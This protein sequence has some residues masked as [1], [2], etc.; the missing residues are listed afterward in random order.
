VRRR[1]DFFQNR[2]GWAEEPLLKRGCKTA[3]GG[4]YFLSSLKPP[5][6]ENHSWTTKSPAP[7][8][9]PVQLGRST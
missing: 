5:D 8:Y 6:L 9:T 3:P 4:P 2:Y 1:R 7:R